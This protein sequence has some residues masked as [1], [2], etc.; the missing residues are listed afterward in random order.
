MKHYLKNIEFNHYNYDTLI[1][2][3]CVPNFIEKIFGYKTKDRKYLGSST[4]WYEITDGNHN[5]CGIFKES[6][7][8]EIEKR[9]EY[10][11]AGQ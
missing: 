6:W 1:T 5:R 11:S 3:E 9:E 4:V 7:L 2:I 8:W 10:K